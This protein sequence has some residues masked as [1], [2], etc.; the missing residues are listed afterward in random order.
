MGYQLLRVCVIV[1]KFES[2]LGIEMIDKEGVFA[3]PTKIG[4]YIREISRKENVQA[5]TRE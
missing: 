2:I 4:T 5:G 1:T 3:Y